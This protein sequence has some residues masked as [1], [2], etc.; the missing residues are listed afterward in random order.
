MIGTIILLYLSLIFGRILVVWLYH[1]FLES[2]PHQ[3]TWGKRA[4]GLKVTS[5]RGE[6][7]SFGHA[8][9]R[10]F[11]TIITNMTMGIGYLMVA[12]T[13]KKQTLHDMIAGTLVVKQ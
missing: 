11:G 8:S 2:G 9:G 5:I 4:V 6:R 10:Y 12:F 13:D 7:I 3:S 1:A